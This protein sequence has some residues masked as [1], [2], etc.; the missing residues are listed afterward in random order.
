MCGSNWLA[1]IVFGEQSNKNWTQTTSPPDMASFII[2]RQYLHHDEVK[3]QCGFVV[4][5]KIWQGMW[6]TLDESVESFSA[7]VIKFFF[8]FKVRHFCDHVDNFRLTCGTLGEK[9][10]LEN[11]QKS[12]IFSILKVFP[13]KVNINNENKVVGGKFRSDSRPLNPFILRK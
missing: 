6:C 9:R 4:F 7:R 3:K 2:V 13:D 8:G 10:H 5:R 11:W 12:E 1:L